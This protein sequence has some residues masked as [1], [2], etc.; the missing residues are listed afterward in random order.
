MKQ[1]LQLEL[2]KKLLKK[3]GEEGFSLIELV[4]VVAVL[5]VLAA[6]ALPTFDCFPKRAKATAAL[7]ALK[8]IQ[9]ECA[10]QRAEDSN[11]GFSASAIQDYTIQTSGSNSCSGAQGTGIISAVP[12]NTNELPTFNLAAATGSLTY[13]FRGQT[14]TNFTECLGLICGDGGSSGSNASVASGITDWKAYAEETSKAA[15]ISPEVIGASC[16]TQWAGVARTGKAEHATDGDPDTKWTCD[17]MATIDF[18]LGKK[19]EIRSVNVEFTGDVA[20]GNYVKVYVDEKLVAE[21]TQP[22]CGNGFTWFI[23]PTEGRNIRYETV[24]QPHTLNLGGV[25]EGENPQLQSA[26]W[27]EIGE[28]TV[29]GPMRYRTNK[30][31]YSSGTGVYCDVSWSKETCENKN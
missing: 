17:G 12:T 23:E 27:S 13:A 19:Q 20:N 29:N 4:V 9:T 10:V 28:L 26:T 3:E 18:D 6:I 30:G 24:E 21:G 25:E 7:A 8:Q 1:Q 2:I 11:Q 5:A 16:E 22:C 15:E 31:H 14:G